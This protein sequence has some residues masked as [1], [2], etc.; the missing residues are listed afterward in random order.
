MK[1]LS[2]KEALVDLEWTTNMVSVYL[3]NQKRTWHEI[4]SHSVGLD[5][6]KIYVSKG[7]VL[8]FSSKYLMS[9]N[10]IDMLIWLS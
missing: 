9:S 2:A 7:Q 8:S 3:W 5:K 6:R 1:G 4:K 10:H